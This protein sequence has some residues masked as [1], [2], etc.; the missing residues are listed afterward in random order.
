[1]IE[2]TTTERGRRVYGDAMTDTCGS[3][4]RVQ[5]SPAR[6]PHVFVRVDSRGAELGEGLGIATL[7]LNEEQARALIERLERWLE[8]IPLA[9][10]LP[11]P[12]LAEGEDPAGERGE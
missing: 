12:L 10:E 4:F 3:T 7:H 11:C 5:E 6:T 2:I 1:M 9:W 8:E